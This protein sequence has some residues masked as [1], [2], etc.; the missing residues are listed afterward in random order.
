MVNRQLGAC[1]P[2]NYEVG[3]KRWKLSRR[4]RHKYHE[5]SVAIRHPFDEMPEEEIR[6]EDVFDCHDNFANCVIK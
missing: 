1:L 3:R 2:L 6:G 4:R 5:D